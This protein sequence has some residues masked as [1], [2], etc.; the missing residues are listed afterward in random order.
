MQMEK[1]K[2]MHLIKYELP[3]QPNY[4]MVSDFTVREYSKHII[5]LQ[6][7]IKLIIYTHIM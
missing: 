4:Q 3:W 6:Q 2:V 1:L 5:F 7:R